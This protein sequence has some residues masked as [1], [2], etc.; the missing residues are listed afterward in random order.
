MDLPASAVVELPSVNQVR[1]DKNQ[2][3]VGDLIA[4]IPHD[5]SYPFAPTNEIEF[6]FR[7]KMY[8][9]VEVILD[10]LEDQEAIFRA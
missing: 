6:V 10:P 5:P 2:L 4:V 8:G 7:V 9:K 3:Q 1:S